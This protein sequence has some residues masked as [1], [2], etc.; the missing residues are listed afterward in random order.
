MKSSGPTT[1]EWL[2]LKR[3]E[4]VPKRSLLV[5]AMVGALVL[6]LQALPERYAA[7]S[8]I[9]SVGLALC[10]IVALVYQACLLRCPRCSGWIAIPKC[11]EC[12][13]K[14][15]RPDNDR[16]RASARAAADRS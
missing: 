12:G 1:Q 6:S 5:A 16:P 13:L 3:I 9:A 2:A 7:L 15:E 8:A 11:P 4:G 10:G 14:L